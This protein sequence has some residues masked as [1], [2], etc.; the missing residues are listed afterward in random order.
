MATATLGTA[1]TTTL[2]AIKFAYAGLLPADMATIQTGILDDS[3][4]AATPRIATGAFVPGQGQLLIPNRGILQVL[5]GDYVAIDSTT[6]WP[7]LLS[8]RAAAGASWVHAP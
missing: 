8:A 3:V 7:I 4:P 6:G 2:T 1:L 5:P